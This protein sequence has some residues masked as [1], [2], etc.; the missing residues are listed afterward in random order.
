MLVGKLRYAASARRAG[1]KTDLHQIWLVNVLKG[2][3]FLTDRSGKRFQSNGTAA[4]V[5]HDG[6]EHPVVDAV[7]PQGVNFEL[8]SACAAA[9]AVMTPS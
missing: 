2:D 8:S 1:K 9:S 7:E 3:G 4:V 6:L 5:F